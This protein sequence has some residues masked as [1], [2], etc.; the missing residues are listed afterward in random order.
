M[1]QS[2]CSFDIERFLAGQFSSQEEAAFEDHLAHCEPCRQLLSQAAADARSWEKAKHYLNRNQEPAVTV[3]DVT[4]QREQS[5]PV[6]TLADHNTQSLIQQ[7]LK[8][9]APTDDPHMLGRLG[10]Y[11]VSGIIGAGGMGIVLKGWDKSLNRVW[12]SKSCHLI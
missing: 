5:I 10:P 2:P 1:T 6:E 11:E 4:A 3:R 8:L 12:P 9:L 7:T